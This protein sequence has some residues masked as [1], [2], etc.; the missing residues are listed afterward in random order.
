MPP[1]WA[2]RSRLNLLS[3][4]LRGRAGRQE[5]GRVWRMDLTRSPDLLGQMLER[6]RLRGGLYCR[7]VARAPWG[8]RFP[9]RPESA[10]HLVMAG[11]CLLF[12]GTERVVLGP[13]DVVL[14]PHGAG[15]ALADSARTPRQ[16]LADWLAGWRGGPRRIGGNGLEAVVLCGFF[17]SDTPVAHPVL[18][19]L[20]GRV[21]LRGADEAARA[22]GP[23]VSLIDREYERGERGASVI[24]S[25]LLDVLLVQILRAW[26]DDQR[27]GEAGWL[28]AV[29]DPI[30]ARALGL[31]HAEPGRDWTVAELAR[32][33]GTSR[34]TLTRRFASEVRQSPHA[35]LTQLRMQEAAHLLRETDGSLGAIAERVGYRSEFAFNRAFHREMGAPPGA[36]RRS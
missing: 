20:P 36:Y 35:Y 28:G 21:H 2:M 12:Q 11:T 18:R 33:A 5:A 16:P 23:T 17:A 32:R 7:T 19:L 25:R 24:L 1:P 27:P 30:L 13:G 34:P 26:A 29:R 22:L 15:H 10:L 31:M 6:S 8:L 3:G 4:T 14:L 9:A